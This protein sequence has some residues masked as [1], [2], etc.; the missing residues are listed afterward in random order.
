MTD[1]DARPDPAAEPMPWDRI[2]VILQDMAAVGMNMTD[3]NLKLWSS[4]SQNLRQR[5]Y[6]TD[7]WADD[8]ARGVEAAMANVQDAWDFW[9]RAPERELVA[10]T[11][12]MAF[13]VVRPY[14][15]PDG[16]RGYVGVDPVWMR[17]GPSGTE[18][19]PPTAKIDLAGGDPEGAKL[20]LTCLKATL[21]DARFAYK[22]ELT[23][24]NALRPGVYSGSV[25]VEQPT[26]RLI[27]NLRVIVEGPPPP[28]APV[29]PMVLMRLKSEDGGRVWRPAEPIPI[30]APSV[31]PPVSKDA[32]LEKTATIDLTGPNAAAAKALADALEVKLARSHQAYEL[33]R[34][35]AAD[36]AEAG[37]Y[38]G[39][40]Y[41]TNPE[42]LAVA[43]LRVIVE[44]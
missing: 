12:P 7:K 34:K 4:I 22:L 43:Y 8:A 29:V 25:Y 40:I 3:R 10:Q 44:N 17:V 6:T 42:L 19:M 21:G 27:A 15:R 9:T 13:L 30:R 41:I 11:V 31:D 23:N 33:T 28:E 20:L 5:P 24:V 16:T 14:H 1:Q 37:T 26:A 38:S 35:K 39:V 18:Q 32:A 36:D 2:G